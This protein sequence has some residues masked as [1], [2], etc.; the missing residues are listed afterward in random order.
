MKQ[1]RTEL[2]VKILTV[3]EANAKHQNYGLDQY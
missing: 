3:T 1:W 2:N